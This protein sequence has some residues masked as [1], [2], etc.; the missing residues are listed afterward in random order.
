MGLKVTHLLVSKTARRRYD[1]I[2]SMIQQVLTW[3]KADPEYIQGK[4]DAGGKEA[5]AG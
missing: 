1:V 2:G 4:E 3:H 5:H